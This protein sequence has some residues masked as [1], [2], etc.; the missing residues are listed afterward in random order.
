MRARTYHD[1]DADLGVLADRTGAVIGYGNQGAAQARNLRDSGIRVVVGNREDAYRDAAVQD[2]FEV[3]DIARAADTGQ[4]LLLLI[5]DEVQSSVVAEQI[6]PGLR[7]GDTLVVASGYNLAFGLLDLPEEIDVVM[8]APRM[9][10]EA[11]RNRYERRVGFP[12]LVSVER[13]VTGTALATA[14]AV[15]KGI[16]ATAAGAVASSAREEAALDLFSE[17]AIWPTVLA[18]LQ[19]S[20]E[21]LADAGFSDDAILDEI[22]LSGEPA[23]VFARISRMGLLDQLRTHSRTSQYGQLSNLVRSGELAETLRRRFAEVLQGDILSGRFAGDWS[24]PGADTEARIRELLERAGSHPL[25]GAEHA[26]R[27]RSREETGSGP[28]G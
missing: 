13:D 25:I 21:V 19:V 17:Q 5:P 15:A 28:P 3:D 24:A 2:G 4:V 8:V 6:T 22:Y 11:V 23:E 9:I 7:A 10:G 26:V 18:V 16:G 14:L 27:A 1:A 20:Y 12:C